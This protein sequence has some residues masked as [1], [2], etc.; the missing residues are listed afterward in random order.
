[1]GHFE[2]TGGPAFPCPELSDGNGNGIVQACDGMTLRD[3]F[4]GQALAGGMVKYD[5]E[6]TA[7]QAAYALAD[8]MIAERSK[9]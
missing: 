8:A 9:P 3:W 1:M 7:S 5:A 2:K 4:A 6:A